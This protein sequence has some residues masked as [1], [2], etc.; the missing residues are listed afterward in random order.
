[1]KK[2]VF[3]VVA[4]I[5][6]LCSCSKD[7]DTTVDSVV[8]WEKALSLDKGDYT[9][10]SIA[11]ETG[12]NVSSYATD[13]THKPLNAAGTLWEVLD[14][15][16]LRIQ[17][18]GNKILGHDSFTRD[19]ILVE[20]LFFD[21]QKVESISGL[22]NLDMSKVTD[23]DFL[24]GNCKELTSL[25]VSGFDTH[26]VNSMLG[27]FQN[28]YKLKSITGLDKFNTSNVNTTA[29]TFADCR[30]LTA[31]DLSS[32]NTSKVTNTMFM[33]VDCGSLGSLTFGPSFSM[34]KVQ[35]KNDM[36]SECGSDGHCYV[37][38]I[39]DPALKDA[40]RDGTGWDEANMEFQ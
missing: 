32:F 11:I 40:L 17:T 38:G 29:F 9:V 30:A 8:A 10:T 31:L 34:A 25:D 14:G 19:G 35:I 12:I 1:M 20:G 37:H 3:I 6:A 39:T 4:A 15:K 26:L 7:D 16:V 18:S 2:Y 28:C 13:A 33:F 5:A 23:M 22:G 21:Y 36:F 27:M 24:F